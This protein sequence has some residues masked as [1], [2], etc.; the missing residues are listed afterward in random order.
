MSRPRNVI[1]VS[2]KRCSA[3]ERFPRTW[4]PILT[5][6]AGAVTLGKWL[7]LLGLSFFIEVNGQMKQPLSIVHVLIFCVLA[8]LP[9]CVCLHPLTGLLGGLCWTHEEIVE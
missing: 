6:P 5:L 4:I 1:I 3:L 7:L 2:S 8:G 9:V